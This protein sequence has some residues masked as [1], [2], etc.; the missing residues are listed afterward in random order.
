MEYFYPPVQGTDNTVGGIIPRSDDTILPNGRFHMAETNQK[1]KPSSKGAGT[2]ATTKRQGTV[3]AT[4]ASKAPAKSK[5]TT[6]VRSAAKKPAKDKDDG[7]KTA[8]IKRRSTFSE[9]FLPYIFGALALMFT[10]F[11][12]LN[13]LE[14]ADSPDTHSGGFIGYYV[15]YFLFGCLGWAA[16]LLPLVFVGMQL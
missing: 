12:I 5:G 11:L 14:G 1:K 16:Y 9:Q 15:C 4:A 13:V 8:K 7:Q 6:T 2:P 10:V 3:T